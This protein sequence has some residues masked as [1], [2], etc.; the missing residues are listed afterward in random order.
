MLPGYMDGIV[1]AGGIPIMLPL[2]SEKATIDQL[3]DTVDGIIMTG[4]HDVSPDIYGE[5]KLEDLV[6]CNEARD[7]MEKELLRQALEK[8]IPILGICRGIQFIN[9]FLG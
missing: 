7:S 6:V 8:D 9:A 1:D 2:T 5:E 4:G 3:L